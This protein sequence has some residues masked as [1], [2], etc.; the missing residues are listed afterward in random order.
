MKLAAQSENK[1]KP[2]LGL[3]RFK[4]EVDRRYLYLSFYAKHPLKT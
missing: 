1:P 2:L 3:L 4:I